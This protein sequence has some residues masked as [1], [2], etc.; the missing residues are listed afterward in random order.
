MDQHHDVGKSNFEQMAEVFA[1]YGVTCIY[2]HKSPADNAQVLYTGL[3][4]FHIVLTS[5]MRKTFNSISTRIIDERHAVK[6]IHGDELDDLYDMLSYA[7]NTW[8]LESVKPDLMKLQESLEKMRLAGADATA[9]ARRSLMEM[10][11]LRKKAQAQ[12]KGLPL[13]KGSR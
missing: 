13:R 1:E 10:A 5:A 3:S 6:K 4:S 9:L 8:V 11:K 12:A 2:A 7:Y